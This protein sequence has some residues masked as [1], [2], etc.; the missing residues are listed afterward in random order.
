[1]SNV[2]LESSTLSNVTSVML[3]WKIPHWA[4]IGNVILSN[5]TLG[6]ITLGYVTLDSI[7]LAILQWTM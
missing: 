3:L 5:V 4:T 6:S 2:I 7:T 1:M